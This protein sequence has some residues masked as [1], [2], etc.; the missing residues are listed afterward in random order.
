MQLLTGYDALFF[1]VN[2]PKSASLKSSYGVNGPRKKILSP[3]V[4]D[5]SFLLRFNCHSGPGKCR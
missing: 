4:T 3:L 2:F 5:G 1:F